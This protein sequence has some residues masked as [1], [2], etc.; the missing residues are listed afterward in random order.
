MAPSNWEQLHINLQKKTAPPVVHAD[1]SGKTV[2]V[3]G[4]NIGL[5]F[6]ACKHFARMNAARVI[7]ACRSVDK[8]NTALAGMLIH[9]CWMD[10]YAS[11]S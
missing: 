6:E 8:G 9:S 3:T 4:A 1:L 10:F 5:G 7:L 11:S 2:I